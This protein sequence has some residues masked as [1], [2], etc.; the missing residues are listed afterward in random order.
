M[1]GNMT[2]TV[3][4][5]ATIKYF[6]QLAPCTSFP[7]APILDRHSP[8]QHPHRSLQL[9]QYIFLVFSISHSIP[10]PRGL[11]TRTPTHTPLI[12]TALAEP[13]LGAQLQLALQLGTGVLAMDEVAEAAAHA[14]LAAVQAAARLAEVGHGRELAVDRARRVPA[15]VERVAGFL[16]RVFVLEASVDVAD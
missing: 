13:L 12:P 4:P 14:A 10:P 15:A 8:D 2:D 3:P 6:P 11:G 5:I 16:R 9:A 1:M 7:K